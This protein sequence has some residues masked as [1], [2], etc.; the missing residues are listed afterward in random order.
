MAT[1]LIDEVQSVADLART[2]WL[3]PRE[4][5][6]QP[7]TYYTIVDLKLSHERKHPPGICTSFIER[8]FLQKSSTICGAPLAGHLGTARPISSHQWMFHLQHNIQERL[9]QAFQFHVVY[10]WNHMH[11]I[12]LVAG[13]TVT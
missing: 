5:T 9:S 10:I 8:M 1:W 7:S 6:H 13:T 12:R 2:L 3:A 11:G 4:Y